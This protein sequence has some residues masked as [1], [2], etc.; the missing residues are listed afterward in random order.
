[1]M[2]V[3]ENCDNMELMARYED[4]YFDLV[5]AD[6]PYGLERFKKGGSIINKY[7]SEEKEWNNNKPTNEYFNELFRVSKNIIIWGGNNFNLP[8]SEYF[9]IWQ[10]SNA[11]DFSFAMVEQAWTNI[12]KPAK[13]FIYYHSECND[14][15]IHPT[16][17]PIA[18][19]K[20]L[21]KNYAKEGD[22]ILDTHV[23]SGSSLI[24]FEDEKFDYVACELDKDY[25]EASLKRL[26]NNR[27]QLELF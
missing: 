3:Y 8:T 13:I 5:I 26:M 25:Y 7:G 27:Q 1:M 24:A 22:I 18:L 10:K 14:I 9:I 16:Q 11:L 20:W 15:R 23:G 4:K 2:Q 21:L 6:P 12:K 17:K 19:Y